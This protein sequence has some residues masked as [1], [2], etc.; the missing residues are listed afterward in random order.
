MFSRHSVR[1]FTY[2]IFVFIWD[3]VEKKSTR[4]CN[5]Q[6]AKCEFKRQWNCKYPNEIKYGSKETTMHAEMNSTKSRKK[7]FQ[8]V[9]HVHI[10]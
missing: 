1:T 6:N 8:V 3:A 10:A 5:I 4:C 9:K 7:K 2:C